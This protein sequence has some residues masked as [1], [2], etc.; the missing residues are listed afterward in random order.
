MFS[1]TSLVP[2]V[3][4]SAPPR[5]ADDTSKFAHGIRTLADTLHA[6]GAVVVDSHW[7]K[8]GDEPAVII[9][10]DHSAGETQAA[11]ALAER[12]SER[13]K[14]CGMKPQHGGAWPR[15]TRVWKALVD[16]CAG[17]SRPLLHVSVPARTERRS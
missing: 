8:A 7:N 10:I 9:D 4:V 3:A 16:A 15:D 5:G 17:A 14:A 11:F 6:S 2:V 12:I 13:L 1:T